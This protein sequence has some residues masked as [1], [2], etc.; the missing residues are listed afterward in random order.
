M[1]CISSR[2]I[3]IACIFMCCKIAHLYHNATQCGADCSVE[4]GAFLLNFPAYRHST[5]G[6]IEYFL[7][8]QTIIIIVK[9]RFAN[10]TTYL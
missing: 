1:A 5:P 7:G 3:R 9:A 6:P 8:G 10:T 4:G 2:A